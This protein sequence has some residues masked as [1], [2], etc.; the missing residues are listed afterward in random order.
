M[1]TPQEIQDKKFEKALFGGYDMGQIDDFL[2]VILADYTALYKENTTLKGKM[3]VLVDKIEEYRAVDEQ[4]RKALYA[5]QVSSRDI[6]TKAQAEAEEIRA[7]ARREADA[8]VG[9]LGRMVATEEQRLVQAKREMSDYA[10]RI[11]MMM[12]SGIA[13]LEQIIQ[14]PRAAVGRENPIEKKQEDRD[15]KI[16]FPESVIASESVP[17]AGDTQELPGGP[18]STVM[19]DSIPKVKLP[20]DM[21][22]K[23]FEIDLSGAYAVAE[24]DDGEEESDTAKLYGESPFT[25]KP[26]F[27][28]TNLQFG[29]DYKDND[30][31]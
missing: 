19:A 7:N 17:E 21:E 6:V 4:M 11:R 18:S 12:A 30:E 20:E 31:E 24:P 25:P 27:D 22:A 9:D 15:F 2:D 8:Q 16:E 29:K 5:A 23:Y 10:E 1:L 13:A 14:A 3:R 26:R 28:F